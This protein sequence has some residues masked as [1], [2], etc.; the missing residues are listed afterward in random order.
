M[1]KK[2]VWII[3]FTVFVSS[4]TRKSSISWNRDKWEP[5][6]SSSQTF[7]PFGETFNFLYGTSPSSTLVITHK[8]QQRK[9]HRENVLP[10]YINQA[11][12][13]FHKQLTKFGRCLTFV[14]EWASAPEWRIAFE[15]RTWHVNQW[16]YGNRALSPGPDMSR[17]CSSSLSCSA[18]PRDQHLEY[19]QT[20]NYLEDLRQTIFGRRKGDWYSTYHQ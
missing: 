4:I 2:T 12:S 3:S 19:H 17:L 18:L 1:E 5:S 14:P 7:K 6:I 8:N 15:R 10:S 16:F 9:A 13:Q 11:A 20:T